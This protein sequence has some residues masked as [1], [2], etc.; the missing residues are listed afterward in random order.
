ML[1]PAYPAWLV[2]KSTL[3]QHI[4]S[5][6][7]YYAA[8]IFLLAAATDKLD[9]YVARSC[10]QI[11]TLGKL[12]D[13]LADKLLISAAL[14]LMVSQGLIE[15]WI[16]LAILAREMAITAVRIAASANKLIL[17]ADR[18]GKLKMVLQVAAIS[19]ILL[20]NYP[21]G[22][23]TDIPVDQLLLYAALFLTVY[24]GYNYIRTNYRVLK[25]VP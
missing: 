23:I 7:L 21:F 5:Y 25:L 13:P 6:G 2:N 16:A 15:A 20:N 12:L 19:A 17:Q 22:F 3:L 4:D 24:S 1:F 11:T 10:N 9:G 8:A 18:Y 14:I